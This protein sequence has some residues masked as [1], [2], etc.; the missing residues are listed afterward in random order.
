MKQ[1]HLLLALIVV[2]SI[3]AQ[4]YDEKI[5]SVRKNYYQIENNIS[6]YTLK[7]YVY[8]PDTNYPPAAYY[9]FWYDED[10]HLVKAQKAMGEEGYYDE[11]NF[12]YHN[13][14]L[15]FYFFHSEE[16]VWTDE[17][18]LLQDVFESRVYFYKEEI[19]EYFTKFADSKEGKDIS[20]MKNEKFEWEEGAEET[21]LESSADAI[22]FSTKSE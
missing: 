13:G 15:I 10:G 4:T 11:E 8:S 1:I 2:L 9:K 6:D 22:D 7:D 20:E 21:I 18:V 12:Y 19:F 16:P 17:G 3:N 5:S 14:E